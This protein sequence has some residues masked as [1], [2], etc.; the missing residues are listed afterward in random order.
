MAAP[1]ERPQHRPRVSFVVAMDRERVIGVDG[2]LPWRLPADMKRFRAISMGKPV[3]MGR[4]T[5]ESIPA[6]FRPLP[7]RHNIVLT[8]DASWQA[9]GCT[10]VHSLEEALSAAGD[11]DEVMV[12]GGAE[13]FAQLLPQ[14]DRVYLTLVDGVFAGDT[15]FPEI[16]PAAWQEVAR[17]AHPADEQHAV[18][19][20]FIVLDRR[21]LAA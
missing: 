10:V 14:A 2:G 20:S 6:R 7:G 21:P 8:R 17:E 13:I 4:R 5:Y 1:E 11:E 9:S 16:D 18:A 19:Y 3:I 15:Y 12:I